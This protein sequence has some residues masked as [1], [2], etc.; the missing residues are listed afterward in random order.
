MDFYPLKIKQVIRETTDAVTLEFEIPAE[1]QEQFAYQQGQYI[2]LRMDH[3][4][5]EIRRSYSMSSSP[6]E[7]RLAVTVKKVQNGR[8]SAFLHD[9]VKVG[10]SLEVAAPDGR[11][12]NTLHP[13]K[14]AHLLFVWSW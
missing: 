7:K 1:L 14:A 11:F 4:G 6:L 5:Q 3:N 13:R 9:D 12:Y 2:T 10:D 8:V